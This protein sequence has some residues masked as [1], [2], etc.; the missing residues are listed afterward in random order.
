[1]WDLFG[2]KLLMSLSF[3]SDVFT[4]QSIFKITFH[5]ILKIQTCDK[6]ES[7]VVTV[8]KFPFRF[9]CLL[10]QILCELR[11]LIFVLNYRFFKI[12]KI[13]LLSNREKDT[14]APC[15]PIEKRAFICSRWKITHDAFIILSQNLK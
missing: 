9:Y 7:D 15:D 10:N 12:W 2:L 3:D 6:N 13:F 8:N 11:I 1:M 14:T 5:N 4:F